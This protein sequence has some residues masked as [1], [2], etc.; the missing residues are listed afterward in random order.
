MTSAST[1]SMMTPVS[2]AISRALP[3]ATAEKSTP[4][5]SQPRRA[6]QMALRPSPVARS[7]ALPAGRSATS[8]TRNWF[9]AAPQISSVVA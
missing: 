1:H 3:R 4:V 6:S 7:S 9:G 2:A 8:R 5:T